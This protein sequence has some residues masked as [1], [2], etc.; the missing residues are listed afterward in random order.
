VIRQY[1]R[2]LDHLEYGRRLTTEQQQAI[3]LLTD[4]PTGSLFVSAKAL[5]LAQRRA[6]ADL[7]AWFRQQASLLIPTRYQRRWARRLRTY[8]GFEREDAHQLALAT[9]GSD[10]PP[11]LLG[12]TVLVT[13]DLRLIARFRANQPDLEVRFHRM[14]SQLQPPYRDALLPD[15]LSPDQLLS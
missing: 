14:V 1:L 7:F 13:F 5:N 8:W 12:V 2:G 4:W 10:I 15:V 3:R 9:F 11:T 6:P